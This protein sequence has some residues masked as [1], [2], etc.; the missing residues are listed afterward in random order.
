MKKYFCYLFLA[1]VVSSW[2]QKCPAGQNGYLF[3]IRDTTPDERYGYV[4]LQGDTVVP[5]SRYLMCYTDTIRTIGF[6]LNADNKFVGINKKGNVL[7]EVFPFDNGPDAPS[8]GLFRIIKKGKIG[9]ADLNGKIV[10]K[11]RFDCAFPF[12]KGF[13]SV[14]MDCR[15]ITKGEHS[16][17]VSDSWVVIDKKG[18]IRKKQAPRPE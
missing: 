6:A 2:G 11:P 1:A 7:F 10:I 15:T 12:E 5:F 14:S 4:N 18:T 8:D 3:L 13:A 16:R 17:W 9:Y